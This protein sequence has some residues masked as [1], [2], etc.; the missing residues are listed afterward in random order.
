M[1]PEVEALVRYRLERSSEALEEAELLLGAGYGTSAVNRLYYA[2]FY[3]A[4]AALLAKGFSSPKHSGIRSLLHRE[5][6]RPGLLPVAFGQFYDQLF[7]SRQRGDYADLVRFPV[8]DVRP[9]LP[10][11]AE[12]VR[13]LRNLAEQGC[14]A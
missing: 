9:W 12:L 13:R 1:S 2:V 6:V 8:E 7:D 14:G 4:S 5:F 11:A 3:A 10:R